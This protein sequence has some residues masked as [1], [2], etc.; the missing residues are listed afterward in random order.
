[1]HNPQGAAGALADDIFTAFQG[2]KNNAR[3][4]TTLLIQFNNGNQFKYIAISF[5]SPLIKLITS[6]K[7]HPAETKYPRQLALTEKLHN[8][9]MASPEALFPLFRE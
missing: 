6:K 2:N 5:P 9:R 3:P 8:W 1:V 7:T 4:H